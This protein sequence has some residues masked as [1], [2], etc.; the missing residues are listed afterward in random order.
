M[1]PKRLA[2]SLVMLALVVPGIA[3]D[4]QPRINLNQGQEGKRFQLFHSPY[5]RVDTFLV[6]TSSGAVWQLAGKENAPGGF[7][8]VEVELL[9]AYGLAPKPGRFTIVFSPLNRQDTMLLDTAGGDV[10]CVAE[11]E[12]KEIFFKHLPRL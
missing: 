12:K 6:D 2:L 5:V 8:K 10:W 11:N 7:Q 9:E 4:P 1:S 3:Q